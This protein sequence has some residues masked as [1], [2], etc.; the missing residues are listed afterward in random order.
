MNLFSLLDQSATRYPEH[1]AVFDGLEQ[2]SNWRELRARALRLAAGI[3]RRCPVDKRIALV[4]ENRP[5]YV[6]LM[7][8][9]WAAEG[10]IVPINYKLHDKEVLQILEDAEAS[11]VFVSPTLLA[12]L[13]RV[14]AAFSNRLVV[15]GE[16]DY[17]SML[18]C[19]ALASCWCWLVRAAREKR[20]HS[21]CWRDWNSRRVGPFH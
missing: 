16:A 20:P 12:G 8:A 2:V 6:E 14:A 10:A 5:E 17:E 3:R 9:A 18:S 19:E 21:G 11:L 13:P 4:S 1:G 15:I 7:F